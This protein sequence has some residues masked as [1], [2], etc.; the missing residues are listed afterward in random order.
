M[1]GGSAA[2]TQSFYVSGEE[3]SCMQGG[4]PDE[5]KEAIEH[6]YTVATGEGF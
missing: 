3:V 2:E 4:L 5:A 6:S 1:L